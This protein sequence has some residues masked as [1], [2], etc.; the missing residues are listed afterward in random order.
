MQ[1]PALLLYGIMTPRMKGDEGLEHATVVEE[2]Q[3]RPPS[4]RRINSGWGALDEASSPHPNPLPEGEGTWGRRSICDVA[5]ESRLDDSIAVARPAINPFP[6]FGGISLTAPTGSIK[7]D[8]GCY[9]P[10][11]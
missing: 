10:T 5:A 8:I 9:L 11:F 2:R 6:T 1:L 3:A 7:I 4:G